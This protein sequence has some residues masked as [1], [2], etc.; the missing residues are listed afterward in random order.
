[1]AKQILAT[2]GPRSLQADT[3]KRMEEAGA[4]L[5]RLNLS[6]EALDGLKRSIELVQS[7]TS[8][9]LCLDS[10]GA[11][12]RNGLMAGGAVDLHAGR[13]IDITFDECVG[14]E[15][16]IS[17]TPPGISRQFLPGDEIRIDFDQAALRVEEV[18]ADRVRAVVLRGGRVGSRKAADVARTLDMAHI[19]PKD[20]AAIAIGREMG[21]R[22]FAYSF[23]SAEAGV[24]EFRREAGPGCFI[25][26][27]VE[28]L[29]G[30]NNLSPIAKATDAIIIDRGDLS[31]QVPIE[32]IPFI[33]RRIISAA[34]VLSTPVYVATNLLESMCVSPYPTRAEANDIVSTLLMGADGLVLAAETAV[35]AFP[36]ETVRTLAKI[37]GHC[38]KWSENTT[39]SEVLAM[40]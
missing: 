13:S 28:S 18:L 24:E 23:A 38:Q 20:K 32:L 33:Q 14:D 27:K 30:L 16:R 6:H 3:I 17:F 39:I 1:M 4:T 36:V 15:G 2:L 40:R 25:I 5:F 35:G 8:V 31:R 22:H 9:P 7:S 37:I 11:Q 10:E 21:I 19:T 12:L 34:R 26:S 29:A